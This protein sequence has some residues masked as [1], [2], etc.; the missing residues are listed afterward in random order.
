MFSRSPLDWG[1][2]AVYFGFLAVVWLRRS[3]HRTSAVDYLLAGR[4]VTLPAFVATLVATWYGGI[5]GVG[6]YSWRYGISNWLVFGVPYYVGALLFAWVF[7]RRARTAELFTIPDLL[8]RHYGRGPA[9]LGALTVFLTSA[10]AAYVLMLGTLFAAMFGLPLVPCV[11]AAAL[12]SLFYISRGGLRTV[13]FTD[14]VQFVLMYAGFVVMLGFLVAR[15]GGLGYLTRSLPPAHFTWNG[16]N[17]AAAI[18]VWYVIALSTLVDPGFWQRAYAARDPGVARQGVLISIVCWIVFDFL[19]TATGLY[20]RAVLPRLA[21]PVFAFPELARVTLPPVALGL[22]YLAMIAT[23]MSTVDS[24]GFIAAETIGRDLI[25]RLRQGAHEERVPFYTRLG[26]WGAA[27]FA[28]A[29]ALARPSVIALWHDVGSI[30]TPTLLLPVGT[31]LLRR[32][33]VGSRWTALAMVL[34]FGVSLA[35]VLIKSFPPAG[36]PAGY[37]LDLEPIYAGLLVSLAVYAAG[38]AARSRPHL[39]AAAEPSAWEGRGAWP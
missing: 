25:W 14:Q 7:A 1:L 29:L 23:V 11:V 8:D 6:E 16:G 30:T 5:L 34:A 3:A 21:E 15:H 13:V 33:R 22:F 36:R 4:R 28:T 12:L 24:Y 19:T 38:W 20:A 27:G 26:L 35:W 39:D 32:G 10:P 18:L 2:I 37:P 17:P 31:A 9:V